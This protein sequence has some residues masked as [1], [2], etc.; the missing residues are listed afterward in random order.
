MRILD[1]RQNHICII[2]FTPVLREPRVLRQAQYF[3]ENGLQVVLV[4]IKT[5]DANESKFNVVGIEIPTE[6]CSHSI[7]SKGIRLLKRWKLYAFNLFGLLLCERYNLHYKTLT[8]EEDL[9]EY[10]FSAIICHDY[11][12]VPLG[13]KLKRQNNSTLLIVDCHEHFA[14]QNLTSSYVKNLVWNMKDGFYIRH[15]ENQCL[16]SADFILTVSDG[17][18]QSLCKGYK[19]K[20]QPVTVRNITPY[21]EM[22]SGAVNKKNIQILYHGLLKPGRCLE[23]LI[24][25]AAYLNDSYIINIRGHGSLEYIETLRYLSNKLNLHH[26]V[27]IL[28]AVDLKNLVREANK[29]DIGYFVWDDF[30]IQKKYVLPNK[31]FEYIMAGLAI[32]VSDLPEMAKIVKA[33]DMGVLVSKNDPRIIAKALNSLTFDKIEYYKQQSVKAAK[34]LNWEIE[35]KKLDFIVNALKENSL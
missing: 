5:N 34:E 25:A 35:S 21:E 12:T 31:F 30:S 11:I 24:H 32:C 6:I 15:F 20:S 19:L 10:N 3:V 28:P 22:R 29:F 1:M 13:L 17:I 8:L 9:K 26:K 7:L 4:G 33:Y 14:S 18:S 27:R 16:N 2:S 23:N